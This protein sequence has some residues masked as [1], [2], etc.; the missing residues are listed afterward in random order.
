MSGCEAPVSERVAGGGAVWEVPD[1]SPEVARY[2]ASIEGA[3]VQKAKDEALRHVADV[4][5]YDWSLGK[6]RHRSWIAQWYGDG[7]EKRQ[8]I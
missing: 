4:R 3:V 5:Q 8:L 2:A 7:T 1:V 6:I